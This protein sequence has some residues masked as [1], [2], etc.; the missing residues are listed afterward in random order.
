MAEKDPG[1]A[2]F[3]HSNKQGFDYTNAFA[4]F[5]LG[6]KDSR[7]YVGGYHVRFGQG[8]VA[9]QGFSMGKVC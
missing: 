9:W 8:L 4:N 3:R 7:I 5:R 6:H 1:E 2:F